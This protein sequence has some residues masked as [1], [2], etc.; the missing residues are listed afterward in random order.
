MRKYAILKTPVIENVNLT[1]RRLMLYKISDDE[2]YVFVSDSTEYLSDNGGDMWYDNIKLAEKDCNEIY[3]VKDEDWIYISDPMCDCQHDSIS[4]IRVKGRNLG[5]PQFGE[6]EFFDGQDWVEIKLGENVSLKG[7]IEVQIKFDIKAR[8]SPPFGFEYRPHFVVDGTS[9]YLGIQFVDL[10]EA[11]LGSKIQVRVRLMYDKVIY[12]A[13][14][15]GT[16][17]IIKEGGR[18]VGDGTVI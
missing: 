10:P 9:N 13:L 14:K 6:Y 7:V 5:K 8:K 3:G 11:P 18:T 16:H 4:P 2:I 12:D 17:F 15:K 1:V